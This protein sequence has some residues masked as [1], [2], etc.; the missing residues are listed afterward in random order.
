[1]SRKK[2][3]TQTILI[4][5]D[6]QKKLASSLVEGIQVD[7]EHPVEVRISER[8]LKRNN[9]QNAL[10]WAVLGDIARDVKV[11]YGEGKERRY[12][13]E[14]WHEYFK[15]EFLPEDESFGH[16]RYQYRKWDYTPNGDRILVGSTTDLTV[17]GFTQYIEQIFAFGAEKG[18]RFMYSGGLA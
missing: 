11:E 13:A 14:I 6:L 15:R 17:F 10:L 3:Q 18:V 12:S 8:S 5:S 2:V 16:T 9:Q 4:R 1:M 7:S